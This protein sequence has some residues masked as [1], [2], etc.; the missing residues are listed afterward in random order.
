MLCN[1]QK[2]FVL[3]YFKLVENNGTCL[4]SPHRQKI[5]SLLVRELCDVLPVKVCGQWDASSTTGQSYWETKISILALEYQKKIQ[6]A[7]ISAVAKIIN[8]PYYFWNLK[9]KLGLTIAQVGSWYLL[10]QRPRL[11]LVQ[12]LW[13][14]ADINLFSFYQCPRYVFLH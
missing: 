6:L 8:L 13:E 2:I 11:I 1:I 12:S 7:C 5:Q 4:I 9:I 14:C 10:S 3:V